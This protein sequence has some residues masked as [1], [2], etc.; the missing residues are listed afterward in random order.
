VYLDILEKIQQVL[1]G[2]SPLI[3]FTIVLLLGMYIFWSGSM[4]TRKDMSSIYDIFFT[5]LLGGLIVGRICYIVINWEQFS[6]FIWY[7]LPYERYGDEI[8]LFRLL[9]WRFMRIWDWGIDILSMFVAFI[10]IATFWV[11]V[12]KKWKWSHMFTTIFFTAE[13]MLAA[14]FLLLGAS[15]ANQEWLTQGVV[16]ILLPLVLFFLKNSIKKAIVGK[17]E[18]KI[19]MVLDIF[20]TLLTTTYVTY[21]YIIADTNNTEKISVIIFALWTLL[22]TIFYM[23]ETKQADITIEKVSSVRTVSPLDINQP[24]KLPK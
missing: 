7:W 14:S 9:P 13:S 16:M 10:L 8:Y 23:K 5:S 22:G 18:L 19:L 17:K 11:S 20:F 4:E 24:I 6:S 21:T 12:V 15:S 1:N 3:L 2:I